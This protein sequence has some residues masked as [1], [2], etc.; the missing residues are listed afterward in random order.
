MAKI[1]ISWIAYNNDFTAGEVNIQGPNYQ[2]HRDFYNGY[3][4][5]IL[6][7]SSKEQDNRSGMLRTRISKDFPDHVIEERLLELKDVIDLAEIQPKIENLLLGL[8][9]N[10]LDIF[11]S[12]GTSI[13][14]LSWY[15]CHLNLGLKSRLIQM[16]PPNKTQS[17][18]PE[19]IE[20]NPVETPIP[21]SAVIRQRSFDD[22]LAQD[23]RDN[24]IETDSIKPVYEKALKIAKAD[25]TTIIYGATGTG[26]EHLAR[27]IWQKSTRSE[28]PF[29]A[30]N[31]SAL[32][33]QLL[34]SRLFGHKKGSFTGAEKDTKGILEDVHQG[35]VFLDE[36][37]DISPYMQQ[38]LLR[39]LQ[40]KEIQPVGGR[41]IKV[42]VRVIAATNKNLLE[43]C[44]EGK[45]RW[46]LYYR[47]NVAEL[48]LPSL[49]ERGS[50]DV[51]RMIDFFLEAKRK[52]YNR[53]HILKLDK[54][55]RQ[56]LKNYHFPGNVRELE[57]IITSFYVYC[58]DEVTINAFPS[59]L[60]NPPGPGSL[61][62]KDVEKE[63]IRKVLALKNG[64]KRQAFLAL[65]Y[66]SINTLN[67]KI[68]EY[69]LMSE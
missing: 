4:K 30:V 39:F 33:D 40:E 69:N 9:E 63:H 6:L 44:Q 15:L 11:F 27:Y 64:N 2:F 66:G 51:E 34:E 48:E 13:M 23:T 60:A 52:E 32:G 49:I 29:N 17:G 46:D 36:I 43:M 16:R 3:D 5:H 1:L 28:K 41:T 24:F 56:F 10:T 55:V 31:C 26:K 22:A 21:V 57:Q 18:K 65:G 20:I 19:L 12:P 68:I 54:E 37:G 35:T 8:A 50:K 7:Y 59:R 58:E 38:S 42:D 45:Y 14:Q 67:K 62:M 47:L 61:L 53:H 25:V